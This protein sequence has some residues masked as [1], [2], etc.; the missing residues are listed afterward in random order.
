[1]LTR[2]IS[3]NKNWLF[4]SCCWCVFHFFFLFPFSNECLWGVNKLNFLFCFKWNNFVRCSNECWFHMFFCSV[5][6]SIR[7]KIQGGLVSSNDVDFILFK[8]NARQCNDFI[9]LK[10]HFSIS[11]LHGFFSVY[12][13]LGIPNQ[14]THSY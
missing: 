4:C 5:S 2:N 14:S 9:C 12:Y 13:S 6:F 1:M 10:F 3:R 7:F 11:F 8:C